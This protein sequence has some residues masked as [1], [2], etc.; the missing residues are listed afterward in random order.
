M[1]DKILKFIKTPTG[2]VVIVIVAVVLTVAFFSRI[3]PV[4]KKVADLV[5]GSETK[6]TA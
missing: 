6:G 2:I 5:P 4:V 3:R 1:K